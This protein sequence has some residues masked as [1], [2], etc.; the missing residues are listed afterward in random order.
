M[1]YGDSIILSANEY[2]VATSPEYRD[3]YDIALY[4]NGN[5]TIVRTPFIDKQKFEIQANDY[6]VRFTLEN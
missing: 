4:Y 3:R 1:S 6:T 2:K 5:V